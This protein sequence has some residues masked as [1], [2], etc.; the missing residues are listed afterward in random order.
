MLTGVRQNQ[1]SGRQYR[2][3][4]LGYPKRCFRLWSYCTKSSG[5]LLWPL[6]PAHCHVRGYW[7]HVFCGFRR[8]FC[9]WTDRRSHSLWVLSR[10]IRLTRLTR[11]NGHGQKWQRDWYPS[12]IH[13]YDHF[14]CGSYGNANHW[15]AFE[16]VWL[17]R[18]NCVERSH[19]MYGDFL[20]RDSEIVS[21][22][23]EKHLESV[24][25]L[26]H[27]HTSTCSHF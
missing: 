24:V 14:V 22:S 3:L 13:L 17:L 21:K 20:P 6:Q 15:G 25:G 5:R 7:C 2:P 23:E 16:K 4:H 1:Q 26:V 8:R 12:R 9:R 27:M 19:S 18:A 10:S 11:G